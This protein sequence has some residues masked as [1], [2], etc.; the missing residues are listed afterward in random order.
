[1]EDLT[2]DVQ[3]A[4]AHT[5]LTHYMDALNIDSPPSYGLLSNSS[6][7][8]AYLSNSVSDVVSNV[9]FNGASPSVD[10]NGASPSA[11]ESRMGCPVCLLQVGVCASGLV[12]SH[13]HQGSKCDGF[14]H[15][16]RNLATKLPLPSL[17]DIDN[18]RS[19]LESTFLSPVATFGPE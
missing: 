14:R 8:N 10:F 2:I 9:D 7:V 5:S 18:F 12:K 19:Q 6:S 16:P 15:K 3:A 13:K 4:I 17:A 1:M 11:I